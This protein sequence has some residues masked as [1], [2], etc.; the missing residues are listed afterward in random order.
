MRLRQAALAIVVVATSLAPMTAARAETRLYGTSTTSIQLREDLD[1]VIRAP[2]YQTFHGGMAYDLGQGFQ[3]SSLSLMKLGTVL[4]APGGTVDLYLLN[5]GLHQ[6]RGQLRLVGGRQLLR[7]ARGVR[8][9]DGVSFRLHPAAAI[10]ID[11][12]A[13]WVR[14][15]ERDD[16]AGGAMLVQGGA[17]LSVLP[18]TRLGAHVGFRAGPDTTPRLDARLSGEVVIPAP[19]APRPWIDASFR[20]DEGG[21]RYVRGGIVFTPIHL[22]DFEFRGRVDQVVDHDGTLARR[23]LSDMTDSP[24]ASVQAIAT[25]RARGGFSASGSYQA[26]R[27]EVGA[28]LESQGHGIDVDA[29]W[30]KQRGGLGAAYVFRSSY[31]GLYHSAGLDAYLRPHRLIRFEAVAR[32]IPFRKAVG[33]WRLAQW[34]MA[35]ASVHPNE[36][37]AIL[38][39]GEYRAGAKLEHDLRLNASLTITGTL[40]KRL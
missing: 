2:L 4:G 23:I 6:Y 14:D 21:P 36:H 3:L 5:V 27:Y 32:A 12:A 15:M 30:R 18:G 29:H 39:G 19:L 20:L 33:P 26:S 28:D 38:V 25:V 40:R 13:G 34:Y 31:G 35:Q 17:G 7:T 11:A 16:A 10:W 1:G 8:I 37:V 24:V 22:F 9:V